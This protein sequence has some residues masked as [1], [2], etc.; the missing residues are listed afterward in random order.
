VHPCI[1]PGP[2][3]AHVPCVDVR[4]GFRTIKMARDGLIGAEMERQ[5]RVPAVV[6]AGAGAGAASVTPSPADIKPPEMGVVAPCQHALTVRLASF[7]ALCLQAR[8]EPGDGGYLAGAKVHWGRVPLWRLCH[9]R[10]HRLRLAKRASSAP[11][12]WGRPHPTLAP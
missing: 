9:T 6:K 7:C 4:W 3:P 8:R 10:N 2:L 11:C 5:G 1:L 12:H